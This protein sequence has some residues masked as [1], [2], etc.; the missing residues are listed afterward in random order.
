MD[1]TDI[2]PGTPTHNNDIF[3]ATHKIKSLGMQIGLMYVFHKWDNS[4]IQ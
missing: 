1:A 3:T 2:D 4:K